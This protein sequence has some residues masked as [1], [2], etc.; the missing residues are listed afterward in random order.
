MLILD[1]Q[2]WIHSAKSFL[3]ANIALYIALATNLPRPYWAMTTAYIVM[4]PVLGGTNS[5]G[6]YR[7][8]GTLIAA[9]AVIVIVPNLLQTP[10]MLSLALSLWL[11]ACLFVSLLHRGP[12]SYVFMLAGYTAAFIGFPAVLAPDAIFSTALARS[13]EIFLGSLCA[14]LVG[15]LVFPSSIKTMVR[16]RIDDLMGDAK[17]WCAQVLDRRDS[18]D[19]LRRRMAGNLSQLD[20]IVPFAKRDDPRM[21]KVDEWMLELRARML[22][23][24]PVLAA[25]EDRFKNL[26]SASGED[27]EL[28][29]LAAEMRAWVESNEIP[30]LDALAAIR[31]R[32]AAQ[33]AGLDGSHASLLRATLRLRLNELAELWYDSRQ[34]QHAIAT[35][36][37][38]PKPAFGLDLRR[39][40]RLGNRHIDWGMLTFSAL[41]P[42][43]TL[44]VYCMLWIAVG[45]RDGASGAMMSA[46]AASFFAAQDDPAPNILAFLLWAVVAMVITG[47]Y[48]FGILPAIQDFVPLIMVIAPTFLLVGL[49]ASRPKLFLP[50]MILITN[51]ATLLSIQN[52]GYV[53]DFQSYVNSSI[54]TIIGLAFAAV[55]TRLF[56]SVGAEWT[57]RRL[58]R[59]GWGVLADAAE[60]RGRQDR[61][62]FLVRMLD[63]L[64][65]LATRLASLP[66][67]SDV[68][69]VDMLD[70][71]R[72]GLNIL[73]LRRARN[74][75][76]AVNVVNLNRLLSMVAAHY[77]SQQRAG[78]GLPP[79]AALRTE[80]D[81]S[82]SRLGT[83]VPSQARDECLLGLVGLRYGLFPGAG[84]D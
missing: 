47:V 57:A 73:N 48:L 20:L 25:I 70:D 29:Q 46:V 53:A 72:I 54:S 26:A 60:G 78:R 35:G 74:Q 81:A 43:A 82:L 9:V 16:Q 64:G 68:A 75:L 83:L 50:G 17:Q 66:D 67:G 19:A 61:D 11:S 14:V 71:V 62:R 21:G 10:V 7:V 13:E 23:M 56:R 30:G 22:G 49:M 51:I 2:A 15:A 55:M 28:G 41:A 39:L 32:I 1:R 27:A 59:Q 3:A 18:P 52:G 8:A 24:L 31:R 6:I 80:L 79:P 12:S 40:V 38:P 65:L 77:R 44:F 76:P 69:A 36:E 45:W 5:R 84:P 4:Q 63:L 34:L 58:I 33:H 37:T 42:G